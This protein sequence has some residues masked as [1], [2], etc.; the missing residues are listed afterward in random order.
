ME[1]NLIFIAGMFLAFIC[2][3]VYGKVNNITHYR[4]GLKDGAESVINFIERS[5]H[6]RRPDGE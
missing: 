6:D 5:Q 3:F 2:G 1:L 4:Q